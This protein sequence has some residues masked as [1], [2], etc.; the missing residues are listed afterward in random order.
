MS[1]PKLTAGIILHRVIES[2]CQYLLLRAYNYWDF[3]K[4]LVETG[5]T[6]LQ[7]AIR[8][9]AEETG[10]Q[11]LNFEW[12]QQYYETA[13]YGD[14]KVARYY[15]ARTDE[16]RVVL[17]INPE[18]GH[19]EHHEYRWVDYPEA[20]QLLSNRVHLALKWAHHVTGCNRK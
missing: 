16:S 7:A 9:V 2:G 10:I 1:S 5:E 4:G 6:P 17:G 3:P 11:H 12:G 20:G 15:L 13:P 14:N 18:L 19:P 8:E